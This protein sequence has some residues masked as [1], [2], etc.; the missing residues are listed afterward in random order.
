MMTIYIIQISGGIVNRSRRIYYRKG[1]GLV[2]KKN[3]GP[4]CVRE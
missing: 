3:H 1:N 4:V 2:V